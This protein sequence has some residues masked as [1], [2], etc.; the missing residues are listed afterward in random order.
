MMLGFVG[1]RVVLGDDSVI[2]RE[3]IEQM[4]ADAPQIEVVA[5]CDDADAVVRA[6][7]DLR[8]DVVVTDIRM[9]PTDIDEGIRVAADSARHPPEI[10]VVVLSQYAESGLRA[11]AARVRLRRAGLPAQG[12]R[13]RPR[14]A[15]GARSRPSQQGGS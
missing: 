3:G 12:A 1:I 9:P 8:P 13:Q 14:A 2:V 15:G 4:L 6:V 11:E 7:D 5:T 10:G